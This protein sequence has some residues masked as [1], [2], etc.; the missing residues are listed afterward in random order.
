MIEYNYV[1]AQNNLGTLQDTCTARIPIGNDGGINSLML[2]IKATNGAGGNLTNPLS[3]CVKE[4]R[5]VTGTGGAQMRASATELIALNQIV[6]GILPNSTEANTANLVQTVRIPVHFGRTLT[7]QQIGLDLTKSKGAVVEVDVDLT[8]LRACGADG[9]VTTSLKI[10]VDCL[11]TLTEIRPNFTACIMPTVMV[12]PTTTAVHT[13]RFD[14]LM[15]YPVV[16]ML[17]Y[18]YLSGQ[19]DGA[20]VTDIELRNLKDDSPIVSSI[21]AS[22]QNWAPLKDGTVLTSW[23]PVKI[24]P[25]RFEEVAITPFNASQVYLLVKELIAAGSVKVLCECL[26]SN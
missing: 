24:C 16:S 4:I 26:K 6:N 3:A 14:K 7:D 12:N 2:T 13:E 1:R 9:F 10:D 8:I 17:L 20:L 11:R 25:G 15:N 23:C 5:V 21:F 19:V 18:A 22:L